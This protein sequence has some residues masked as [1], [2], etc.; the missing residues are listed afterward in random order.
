VARA[1]IDESKPEWVPEKDLIADGDPDVSY[2]IRPISVETH[3][4]LVKQF[5]SKV[6]NRRTHRTDDVVDFEAVSD[7]VYDF[8]L[9][10]WKG[11][12]ADGKPVP[13]DSLATK[14]KLPGML[15]SA[16]GEYAMQTGGA[17]GRSAEEKR[18]SFRAAP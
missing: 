6:P 10:A 2:Q 14:K 12:E 16:I 15:I 13:C 18:E 11:I 7:A 3:R 9:T 5:T 4:S 8:A 17:H 1:L